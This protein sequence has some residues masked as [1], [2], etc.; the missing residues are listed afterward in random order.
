MYIPQQQAWS[1]HLK[2]ARQ[3]VTTGALPGTFRS[4]LRGIWVSYP[5]E[6]LGSNMKPSSVDPSDFDDRTIP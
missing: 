2:L 6:V 1:T 5:M 3:T 4:R